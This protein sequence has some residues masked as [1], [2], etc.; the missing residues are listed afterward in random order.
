[1]FPILTICALP[2]LAR[3]DFPSVFLSVAQISG[4][5]HLEHAPVSPFDGVDAGG[6]QTFP[7]GIQILDHLRLLHCTPIDDRR[8][9]RQPLDA[10]ED[11]CEQ[12]P[13]D[14]HFGQLKR[15]VLRVPRHLRTDLDELLS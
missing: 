7:R 10:I 13:R 14:S 15:H 9:Q 11:R 4:F 12:P 8:R 3:G 2:C 1:M 5:L 6:A